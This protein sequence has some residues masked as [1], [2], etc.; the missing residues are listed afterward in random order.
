MATNRA[1]V[2]SPEPTELALSGCE[3]IPLSCDEIGNYEGRYEYWEAA[4]ETAWVL[5]DVSP[6]HEH[7]SVRLVAL[8]QDIA[9]IRGT[10]IAMYGTADLQERDARGARVRAA[11][12]DQLI[13]LETPRSL[14]RVFV[15][16]AFPLPDVVFEVDLTTDIRDRKLDVYAAWGVPELWVEVPDAPMPSKR[17]RPGLTINVLADGGYKPCA[18]S[19]AFPTWSPREIHAALNEPYTSSITVGTLRRVGEAMGRLVGT[20]P[21]NDPFL[22]ME[23]NINRRAG[24]QDGLREGIVRERL[25][26][27]KG[28]L[29][30]RNIEVAGEIDHWADRMAEMTHDEVLQAALQSNDVGDF[31][32]RLRREP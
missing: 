7:P 13:Y 8:V 23:R 27:V 16:D 1:V 19:V 24:R 12:A 20:G 25:S 6:S 30:A 18:A 26:L 10:P 17:K 14:P 21:D 15:V 32:G 31:L 9:K 28:L 3:P 5:R 29:A 2:Q 11:Q 4:T 22:G